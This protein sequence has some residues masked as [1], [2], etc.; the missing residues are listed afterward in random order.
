MESESFERAQTVKR[1]L[2]Q[3]SE[4]VS[5]VEEWNKNV[6][7]VEDYVTSPGGLQTM[8]ATCMILE[9]FGE[10]CKKIDKQMPGFLLRYAPDYPWKE[11]KGLRDVIAHGYF[12]IDA[13]LILS[14]VQTE[15]VPLKAAIKTLTEHVED[16]I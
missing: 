14:I 2:L 8:A 11:L 6:H 10:S 9:S 13:E 3:M 4:G 7:S 15:L 12:R 5:L 16:E 1:T